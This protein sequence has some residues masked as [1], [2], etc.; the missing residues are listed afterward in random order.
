MSSHFRVLLAIF[1]S[2]VLLSA[3]RISAETI[4]EP[5]RVPDGVII[6]VGSNLL[7]LQVCADDIIRVACAPSRAFFE[8]QSL[9]IPENR[10]GKN[11]NVELNAGEVTLSTSK[12][13]A[14]V[15]R[16]TG[17]VSFFD[18]H[19]NPVLVEKAGSRALQPTTVQGD[20]TFHVRQEWQSENNEALYGLGQHQL[21]LMDIKGY[22]LDLWQFNG[23]IA[24]PFLVSSRGYGIFWDNTSLTRF[25]DLREWEPIP[26]A[27]LFDA[28]GKPGGLSASYFAGENFDRLLTRRT[29]AQID[30]DSTNGPAQ[31]FLPPNGASARWEGEV[32]ANETGDYTFQTFANLGIKLWVN[33]Q[34]VISYWRQNWLNWK[35]VAKVHF[36]AGHRYR[37]KLEYVSESNPQR[38]QLRWKTPSKD[39][40][41]S[42]WSEVGDGTDYYFCYGPEL[43]QVIAGYRRL[44]GRASLLPIWAYGLWQ[45]R[46]RYETSQQ[47]LDV[48]AGYRS[49][50][51]P[52]DNIVQDWQYWKVDTWGSHEF[53][54][55]RFP[56]PD[57]WIRA[58]HDK[59]HAHLMISVWPKFYPGTKNF[60]A[61]RS[62]GFLFEAPLGD[63]VK[64]WLGYPYTFYDA[65]NP[66]ARKLYWSQINQKLFSKGVD[67]WWM[68][69]TEPELAVTLVEQRARMHPTALGTGTRYL[70]A[71]PLVNSEAIYEGQ[72]AATP[73][74]RVFILTRSGFA[75]QQRYAAAV[76]SGD[77]GS[78]WTTMRTQ[79]ST[80]LGY[81]LSGLP[82][83]T[84][85]IGGFSVPQRFSRGDATP[86]NVEEWR[87]LNARWF[88]FGTFA[89][90]LRVHGETPHREMWEFG[91]ESH[92]AYRAE[93]KFDRLRYHLLPYIYSVAGNVTHKDSTIMRA[94]VMDFRADTNAWDIGDEFMFGPALLVSP[95]TTY[96][97]RSRSVYLPLSEGGWYD[98][99][100][101]SAAKDGQSINAAAPYDGIPL[102]V[103]AGAIIPTGP[104]L[105][106]TMEKPAD[107]ITI[108]VY[109][110]ANGDF[111]LYE[112]GG[113]DYRYENGAFSRIPLKWDDATKTLT[114]G[115][116]SGTF[117][118]MLNSRTFNVI[119]ISNTRPIA[120]DSTQQPDKTVSYSGH[121]VKLHFD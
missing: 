100:S 12:L 15:S 32:L 17:A 70:N 111:T 78:V 47:S 103:R 33:D 14:K 71:F 75:G 29:E 85:D 108:H 42:L 23:T 44:T 72:R 13:M 10:Y 91:G 18:A 43:D 59:Y 37:L 41:I 67:A 6:P 110:G 109:A 57:G 5:A 83:W 94:L 34:L 7:K 107:P 54:S 24:I 115:A 53:D 96:Q 61:L 31:D 81:C 1:L 88:E 105:Q 98:F 64:D 101:G 50:S 116:R 36:E 118:G 28:D 121:E 80:G 89:P 65:F 74:Q 48:L 102:Y 79:I 66:A 92:P 95:V 2:P 58:I 63:E 104:D 11:W 35:N 119:V 73:D 77:I 49:R 69:A 87:E 16:T 25:G 99:W 51:I 82:Y 76:W 46:Q 120:Y 9:A 19:G 22:D 117:K 86:E 3:L 62:R 97:A 40:A 60:A 56:D 52:I 39:N 45:C 114:I 84:M 21:G 26:A 55:S 20:Q 112:D 90:L 27:Q 4:G 30:F 93:L 113:L 8:R 68:D 38:V 106:Y